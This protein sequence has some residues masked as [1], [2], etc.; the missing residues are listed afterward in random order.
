M[1]RILTLTPHPALDISAQADNVAPGRKLRCTDLRTDPGGGGVNVARGAHRLGADVCAILPVGGAFGE[2][3]AALVRAEGVPARIVETAAETRFAFAARDRGTGEQYRFNLPGSPLAASES[4]ALLA[5]L[6]EEAGADD[7]VVGSGSLPPEASSDFWARAARTAREAGAR[8]VLD[9]T[10]GEAEA[11]REGLF[12][13]RKNRMEAEELAGRPLPWPEEAQAFAEEMAAN[14]GAENVVLTHGENGAIMARR[15]APSL[16]VPGVKVSRRSAVGAGDS[17]VAALVV[18][19]LD[20]RAPEEAL[21][22]GLA[23]AAAAMV[24]PGTA[25]FV[26]EDIA[27]YLPPRPEGA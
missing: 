11:L 21:A 19:L 22:R 4:Q 16:R 14:R 10:T 9:T 13:L 8:F 23:A 24:S 15:G 27:R 1:P 7:I 26:P 18:A 17:L 5:A 12:L 3:L 20:G 6:A 2:K 25:L